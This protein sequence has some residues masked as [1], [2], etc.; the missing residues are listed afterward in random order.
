MALPELVELASR[1]A[2]IERRLSGAVRHG[3]VAKVDTKKQR[4][5]LD[6]GPA[7]GTDGRFLSPWVPY[8]QMA[9]ALKVYTPPAEGQQYTLMSP[10]G[11]F[12]QAVA[13]PLT[14]SDSNPSPSDDPDENVI[15]YGNVRM[16][17]RDDLVQI[18]VGG[19]TFKITGDGIDI[20]GGHVCHDGHNIG[21]TH[22]HI[23]VLP[24]PGTS[25]VP[26]GCS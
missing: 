12:R 18:Q 17:L 3:R 24:G 23:E 14:W 8:A 7:H 25:G 1:V 9:G 10:S 5:R 19:V 6:L 21:S 15:T 26:T 4:M 13:L 16:T 22:K 20:T 2:D 11:D